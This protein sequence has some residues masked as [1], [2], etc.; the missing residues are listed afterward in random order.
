MITKNKE[1]FDKPSA[2]VRNRFLMQIFFE[3]MLYDKKTYILILVSL[4]PLLTTM[5]LNTATAGT[6]VD[7]ITSGSIFSFIIMPLISLILGI[8]AIADEKENKTISQLLSRPIYR[9]EIVITK[10][11]STVIVG[12]VIVFIDALIVY[13]GLCFQVGDF[14]IS[15]FRLEVLIG[16]WAYLA[17]WFLVYVTIFIFLGIIIDS[18]ALGM[19]L[20]IAYF[21]AFFS[22]FIFGGGEGVNSA[23]SIVNHVNQVASEFLISDYYSFSIANYEP[24]LSL[25]TCLALI[26]AFLAFS[27]LAMRRKDF[28]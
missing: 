28:P 2:L 13:L 7:L 18:N 10:W 6:Y 22:Q 14:S 17:I 3:K 9:E 20:A 27:L 1:V 12:L 24:E 11:I 8:S 21:E 4:F 25:L 16:A 5:S 15:I 23:F 19:G 26:V